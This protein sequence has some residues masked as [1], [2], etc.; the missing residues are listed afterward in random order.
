[1]KLGSY[2]DLRRGEEMDFTD[3]GKC[4]KGCGECCSNLLPVSDADLDRLARYA[5]EHHIRMRHTPGAAVS[6]KPVLDLSCPFRNEEKG[7]CSVYQVRPTV[8]REYMCN[9]R[10]DLKMMFRF[11]QKTSLVRNVFLREE[12]LKRGVQE[13]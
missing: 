11:M 1:M 3:H 2:E 8:C 9:Q 13:R 4:P 10:K 6:S 7:C 5:K 12:M